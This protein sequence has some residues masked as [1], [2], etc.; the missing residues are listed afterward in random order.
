LSRPFTYACG[1]PSFRAVTHVRND[2]VDRPATVRRLCTCARTHTT[3]DGARIRM[4]READFDFT[5]VIAMA[6]AR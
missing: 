5:D 1:Y 2:D 3:I 6:A 4:A